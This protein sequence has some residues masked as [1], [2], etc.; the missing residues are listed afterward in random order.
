MNDLQGQRI[1]V[2][3]A[4][5]V[6]SITALTLLRCGA[7]VLLT[8]PARRGDNASGVAAGMLAPAFEA[9]LDPVAC[10]QFP[11]LAVARDFWPAL[12]VS[13]DIGVIDRAGALYVPE[14]EDDLQS[15]V[16]GLA[17]FDPASEV[18]SAAKGAALCP[19]LAL[20]GP[21]LFS[22]L[23]W[24]IEPDAALA[25]L[26]RAFAAE[27]GSEADEAVVGWSKGQATLSSGAVHRA[28]V[29]VLATGSAA[30]P[31]PAIAQLAQLTPIKGQILR[32]RAQSPLAGPTVRAPGIYVA[33]SAGGAVVGATMQSGRNDRR[34]EPHAVK[35]LHTAAGRLFPALLAA[36]PT[37]RAG[38][39]AATADGLPLV[40][41]SPEQKGV[42]L[43]VGARRNGWLLAPAMADVVAARLRGLDAGA[44]GAAFDP[45]RFAIR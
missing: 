43:A 2:A 18:V 28:D 45:S 33:P 26:Q 5:A 13:L 27:G 12:E 39:R 41:W 29:L 11:L 4:G 37:A 1:V 22:G 17:A 35:R 14:D 30:G 15:R 38:V 31:D 7:D 44:F 21:V 20:H 16:R 9:L 42:M 24:R 40:G 25:A 8:D 10:D 32:F 6:G 34:I 23:D 36:E 3:G 19:G